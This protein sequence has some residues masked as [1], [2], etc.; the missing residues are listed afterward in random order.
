MVQEWE[1]NPAATRTLQNIK[2][3]MLA[4]YAKENKRNK[5]TA[6]QLR[7]NAI[8]EQTNATEELIANL[9]ETH[10][11]QIESLI[12]ANTKA[13]KEMLTLVKAQTNTLTNPTN[14]MNNEK[15]RKREER[16][17]NFINAPGCK[18]CGKKHPSKA[19]EECLEL[20]KNAASCPAS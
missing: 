6:K 11:P 2:S 3:F 8:E 5:L 19:E 10:T 1:A 7:A 20:D 18:H 9:T 15:K 13:M 16:Q 14:S 17:K 12:R 4:E